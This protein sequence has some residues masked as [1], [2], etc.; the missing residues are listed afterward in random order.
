VASLPGEP[1][2]SGDGPSPP[3]ASEDSLL[4]RL[5]DGAA[6]FGIDLTASQIGQYRQYLELL[7][8]WNQRLNLTA[9]DD[10]AAVID[11]HFVDSLSCATAIDFTQVSRLVD[12]GT[13]A[14]FPGLV[15]KL[16]F[17]HLQVLLLDSV[18]KRLRFLSRVAASLQLVGAETLHARAEDAGRD[19]S[20]REQYDLSVSRA[21]ARL[22]TLAEY[23]LPLVRI[24]GYF[25]AQK[26]PEV[27]DE[28]AEA[29]AAIRK[30]GG[31][32]PR[33]HTLSLPETDIGRSLVLV[34][35]VAATPQDLPRLPGTPK[36]HPL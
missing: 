31:G 18:E 8:E 4:S 35:K 25:L 29:G 23:S 13:G 34:P 10:P 3:S 12:V 28:L 14:G 26:G 9:I 5:S 2:S 24:G 20:H 11:K 7:L 15:L 27:A 32:A 33:V 16:A 22:N 17:P 21:V 6:R 30:L 36:K 1:A 19:P